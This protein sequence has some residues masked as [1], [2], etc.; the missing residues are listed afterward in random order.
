VESG[1]F[2]V[3]AS[4]KPPLYLAEITADLSLTMSL[5][6]SLNCQAIHRR[7]VAAIACVALAAALGVLAACGD[8]DDGAESTT[9][10]TVP[11]AT[12]SA[13]VQSPA[14]QDTPAVTQDIDPGTGLPSTF[15]M[16]F[17]VYA[18]AEILRA[19]QHQDR[20]VIDWRTTD[21]VA[22]LVDFYETGLAQSPWQIEETQELDGVTMLDFTGETDREFTGSLAIT[23]LGQQTRVFLNLN[24]EE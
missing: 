2:L 15:P 4:R 3:A 12:G 19:S 6:S 7:G 9:Q 13:P 17:P 5:S 23:E 21:D 24:F 8:D 10:A 1:Y 22:T 18:A 14:D 20:Y 16:E 11:G